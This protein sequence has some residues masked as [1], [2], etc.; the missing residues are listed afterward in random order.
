M[1]E[2]AFHC[3]DTSRPKAESVT[4][5]SGTGLSPMSQAAQLTDLLFFGAADRACFAGTRMEPPRNHW[6]R[7]RLPVPTPALATLFPATE[8]PGNFTP[9]SGGEP[10]VLLSAGIGA[11]PVL[12]MRHA[13]AVGASSKE[14][15]WLYGARCRREHPFAKETRTLLKA[16]VHGHSH[17]CY[18]SPDP[19]G[20][21]GYRFRRSQL[22]EFAEACD[23]PVRWSCR[24]GV[25]HTCETGRVFGTVGYRPDPIDAP[26]AG[27]VLICCSRPREDIVIDL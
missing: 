14:I 10:V 17:V 27:N 15:W 25:C 9:R 11:T 22:F 12:A 24:T 5:V 1:T 2:L 23:I 21:A 20:S 4:H 19:R 13:L 3:I 8:R 18:S 6:L 7:I 26:A 16:L